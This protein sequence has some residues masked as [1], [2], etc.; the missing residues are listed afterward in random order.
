MGERE[1]S[2]G[3]GSDGMLTLSSNE[4]R[5]IFMIVK[6]KS[7]M[8]ERNLKNKSKIYDAKKKSKEMY[9]DRK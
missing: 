7:K 4:A 9:E 3:S 8:R 1:V 6:V 5:M 2:R